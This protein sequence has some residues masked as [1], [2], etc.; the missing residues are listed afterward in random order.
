MKLLKPLIIVAAV[1][2]IFAA[3]AQTKKTKWFPVTYGIEDKA[4]KAYFLPA[5]GE[6][7]GLLIWAH[8]GNWSAGGP[9]GEN[10]LLESF[11]NEGVSVLSA[12]MRTKQ[13]GV[14]PNPILDLK[15]VVEAASKGGC[16]TCDNPEMW[17]VI[18]EGARRGI[19]LSGVDSGGYAAVY[20]AGEL[21]TYREDTKLRCVGGIRA[22]LDLRPYESFPKSTQKLIDRFGRNLSAVKL[23][24]MSPMAKLEAGQWYGLEKVKWYFHY[25]TKDD[26]FPFEFSKRFPANL[27]KG[28]LRVYASTND[29]EVKGRNT[30]GMSEQTLKSALQSHVQSCFIY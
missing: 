24:E 13:A 9:E 21:L 18:K 15:A 23:A 6:S 12:G 19:M 22:P 20:A 5:Q 17:K 30:I 16:A 11:A 1:L 4:Q 7:K 8:R 3:Q 10:K 27:A 28:G 25:A 29:P 26:V 14:F 2:P